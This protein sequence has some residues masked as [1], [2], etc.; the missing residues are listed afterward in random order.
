M[1]TKS[2]NNKY[3]ALLLTYQPKSRDWQEAWKE[4]FKDN[5]DPRVQEII[6]GT[7]GEDVKITINAISYSFIH[8]KTMPVY[9][10]HSANIPEKDRISRE[11][12]LEVL[13]KY[14]DYY[15]TVQEII[16][17]NTRRT[18][19]FDQAGEGNGIMIAYEFNLEGDAESM[20]PPK[21]F[22]APS[23]RGKALTDPEPGKHFTRVKEDGTAD[24]N[25]YA[26]LRRDDPEEREW[27]Y[28]I[29]RWF[30]RRG[31]LNLNEAYYIKNGEPMHDDL[32]HLIEDEALRKKVKGM[33][34]SSGLTDKTEYPKETLNKILAG[35]DT[36]DF[37]YHIDYRVGTFEAGFFELTQED[38]SISHV[39]WLPLLI[40]WHEQDTGGVFYVNS[41]EPI[42]H[43]KLVALLYSLNGLVGNRVITELAYL[44]RSTSENSAAVS[45]STRNINHNLGS[46]LLGYVKN[47]LTDKESMLKNGVL[48]G[49][50]DEKDG[51]YAYNDKDSP[52]FLIG[53]GKMLAYFQERQDYVGNIATGHANYMGEVK[54]KEEVFKYFTDQKLVLG[55]I[56][57]SEG[58]ELKNISINYD[59]QIKDEVVSLPIGRTGRQGI[60]TILENMLRNTAKHGTQKHSRPQI[61]IAISIKDHDPSFYALTFFDNS[62]NT[63][64]ATLAKVAESLK[65]GLTNADGRINEENKGIKEMQIAA[66]WMR[67]ISLDRVGKNIEGEPP[68]LLP[69]ISEAVNGISYTIY[70]RKAATLLVAD[71]VPD[72]LTPGWIYCEGTA[73]ADVLLA[74]VACKFV[75]VENEGE[76]DKIKQKVARAVRWTPE[77]KSNEDLYRAWLDDEGNKFLPQGGGASAVKIGI[78]D[79]KNKH[80]QTLPNNV[81]VVDDR[82]GLKG[83]EVAYAKHLDTQSEYSLFKKDLPGWSAYVEAI[84][85][86]NSTSRLCRE[87]TKDEMWALRLRESALTRVLIIDERLWR[88]TTGHTAEGRQ[89]DILLLKRIHICSMEFE[90]EILC[91]FDTQKKKIA[92][93]RPDGSILFDYPF[94]CEFHFVSLHQ[95]LLDRMRNYSI[96]KQN[97]NDTLEIFKRFKESIPAVFHHT[98]HSGRSV[99]NSVPHGAPFIPLPALD[100]ALNDS[101]YA[102]TSLFYSAIPVWNIL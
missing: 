12:G 28:G 64:E 79:D 54:L 94:P 101:K 89:H 39:Y 41:D 76:F 73:E 50:L 63:S 43:N 29:L 4:W 16:N 95:G 3:L 67:G 96:A 31:I 2:A 17:S 7:L 99:S 20:P 77:L 25:A 93:V 81:S 75:A 10:V 1:N 26:A 98:V 60:M 71:K 69:G 46:H 68:L 86:A 9:R 13:G 88:N 33:P 37:R 19:Y 18:F 84:S 51:V 55:N 59:E 66:A 70:L 65:K 14:R 44:D 24:P 92:T 27:Q 91:L 38:N 74:K 23:K 21:K 40:R 45:V 8:K 83:V 52:E 22:S 57:L 85:G 97:E 56:V 87:E 42:A 47:M 5:F 49:I 80:S 32:T 100:S 35:I 34:R 62:G 58:Y 90:N 15:S 78:F 30:L 102:V 82:K 61:T 6:R 72:V 36:S 48:K 11:E 53:L